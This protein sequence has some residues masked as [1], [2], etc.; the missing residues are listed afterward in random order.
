MNLNSLP[1]L[2]NGR[3]GVSND[4]VRAAFTVEPTVTTPGLSVVQEVSPA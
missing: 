4:T 3:N 1:W 2:P